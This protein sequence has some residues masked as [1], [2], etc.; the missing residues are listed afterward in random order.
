MRFAFVTTFFGPHRFGGDA[1]YVE[2]L[3]AALVRRGHHVEVFWSHDAF[4]TVR[5][6]REPLPYAPPAGLVTHPLSSPW[7][8][9]S[10]IRVHQSGGLGPYHRTLAP[11]LMAGRFDV[12]HFH[13]VSLVGAAELLGLVVPGAVRLMTVHDH[14]LACPMSVRWRFDR[15]ACPAPTCIRCMVSAG[16]P[17]QLWRLGGGLA[18]SFRSLDAAIFPS[19]QSLAD[20]AARGVTHPRATVLPYFVP[21]DWRVAA[22][23]DGGRDRFLFVGRLVKEKGLQT[24]LPLFRDRPAVDLDV[25]GDG[26]FR[27]AL[28]RSAAAV[29]NVRFHG[30]LGADAIRG[31]LARARGLL[32]PSLFPETLGYVVLEAWSQATP[33]LVSPAGA[34]ADL[35]AGGGGIVCPSAASF[36]ERMDQWIQRPE[37]A[38]EIGRLGWQRS[39]GEFAE[40]KHV[41]AYIDLVNGKHGWPE[42]TAEGGRGPRR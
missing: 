37:G 26:P 33:V 5:G 9:W 2:R 19:R 25:V 16:R 29:P 40:D 13:N 35:V 20:H 18:R 36:A 34:L 1:A 32:V 30:A 17:P 15:E 12:V 41:A 38:A 8:L 24:L 21:D 27:G 14:R 31:Y 4:E 11:R 7:P 22:P 39:A 42:H 23:P 6:R 3:A 10:A 28:E